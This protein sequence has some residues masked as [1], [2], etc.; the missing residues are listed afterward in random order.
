MKRI[1]L[2]I[3]I[4]I[5]FFNSFAQDQKIWILLT[6]DVVETKQDEAI[7]KN[8]KLDSIITEYSIFPVKRAFPYSKNDTLKRLIEIECEH[9]EDQFG[10]TIIRKIVK[11]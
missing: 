1:F 8:Q 9:N 7:I 11:N 5:M 6:S 2:V 3:S 4:V 10:E